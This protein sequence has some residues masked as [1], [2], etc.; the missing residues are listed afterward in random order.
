MNWR[1]TTRRTGE[2]L[3][4]S[5]MLDVWPSNMFQIPAEERMRGRHR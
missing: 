4:L 1:S 5:N 2:A 3:V